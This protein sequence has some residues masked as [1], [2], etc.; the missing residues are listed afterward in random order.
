MLVGQQ[1]IQSLCCVHVGHL[2][3]LHLQY[4]V[5]LCIF[6]IALRSSIKPVFLPLLT[7][8]LQLS[9]VAYPIVSLFLLILEFFFTY[10]IKL[11]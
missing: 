10:N 8:V 3:L 7:K 9:F 11:R 6:L 2:Q 4:E 1:S 5:N